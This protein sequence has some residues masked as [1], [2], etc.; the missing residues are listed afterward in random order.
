MHNFKG[1]H[2][3]VVRTVASLIQRRCSFQGRHTS[4]CKFLKDSQKGDACF[5]GL[6]KIVMHIFEA[7]TLGINARGAS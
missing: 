1:L 2:K 7:L 4:G 3:T 5:E 6:H